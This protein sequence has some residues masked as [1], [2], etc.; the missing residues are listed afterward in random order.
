[1]HM[2]VPARLLPLYV[3]VTG[4]RQCCGVHRTSAH[5]HGCPRHPW[6]SGRGQGAPS[7]DLATS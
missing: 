1:V 5:L 4:R 6:T 2:Y 7:L 3:F